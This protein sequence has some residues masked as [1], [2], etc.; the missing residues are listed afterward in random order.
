MGTMIVEYIGKRTAYYNCRS[1]FPGDVFE[2]P[3]HI[4]VRD[5]KGNPE[6]DAEGKIIMKPLVLGKYSKL[7]VVTDERREEYLKRNP[8]ASNRAEGEEIEDRRKLKRPYKETRASN[9]ARF[10]KAV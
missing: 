6:T 4:P 9:P 3:D 10:D 7:R 2:I 8:R 5:E 1:Y